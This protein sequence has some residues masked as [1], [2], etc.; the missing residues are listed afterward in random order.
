MILVFNP[1]KIPR[2]TTRQQWRKMWRWKRTTEK[3]LRK[4]VDEAMNNFIV[5]GTT[6]TPEMRARY[7]DEV[8]NPPILLGSH[9]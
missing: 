6:W 7:L 5:Y 4:R 3:E 2:T 8:V 9:Q 1:D